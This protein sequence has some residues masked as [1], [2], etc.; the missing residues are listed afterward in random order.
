MSVSSQKDTNSELPAASEKRWNGLTMHLTILRLCLALVLLTA[1]GIGIPTYVNTRIVASR[2][3][4]YLINTVAQETVD[5]CRDYLGRANPVLEFNRDVLIEDSKYGVLALKPPEESIWRSRGRLLVRSLQANVQLN[6][7]Y[8]GDKW[9]DYIGAVRNGKESIQIDHR[10]IADKKS[11]RQV[12]R[13]DKL[14]IWIEISQ[15][16]FDYDPRSRPWYKSALQKKKMIWT[17]PYLF[18]SSRRPGITA[19]LPLLD[20]DKSVVGVCGIDYELRELNDFVRKQ[21]PG[22]DGKLIILAGSSGAE[23]IVAQPWED[24]AAVPGEKLSVSDSN[25]RLMPASRSSQPVVRSIGSWMQKHSGENRAS[26]NI[27]AI[28]FDAGKTKYLAASLPFILGDQSWSVTAAI[29]E[30]EVLGDVNRSGFYTILWVCGAI[31][32]ASLGAYFFSR[33]VSK[34]LRAIAHEMNLAGSLEISNR[35]LP[36]SSVREVQMMG[37]SL[38]TMKSGLRAFE[39]YVSTDLVRAI[40]INKTAVGLGGDTQPITVFF[41]DVVGFT[42]YSEHM[43]PAD[44]VSALAEYLEIMEEIVWERKGFVDK[45][46]GDAVMAL[47]D[48]PI[49]PD[50]Q[51]AKLA[52]HAALDCVNRL[53]ELRATRV[54]EGQPYFEINIGIHTGEALVGNIGSVRRWNYTAMGDT[55]NLASRIEPLNRIYGTRIL[56]SESTYEEVKSDFET[57]LIDRVIVKGRSEPILIFELM[58]KAGELE[59]A[60]KPFV[61]TYS[62]GWRHYQARE[63]QKAFE[64]FGLAADLSSHSDRASLLLLERCGRYIHTPPSQEWDGAYVLTAK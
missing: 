20:S 47:W 54:D 43:K 46:I 6:Q 58:A 53:S 29:P 32:F 57:R 21:H 33:Q 11:H 14:G 31:I 51:A 34:P 39:K 50:K 27:S 2:L 1:V 8:Y 36:D 45:Y 42:S 49:R 40:L 10:W 59:D 37:Q 52:C 7:V 28:E 9:G 30:D 13:V 60:R 19:A 3:A 16:Q 5:K 4:N 12:Y 55:V 62:Q 18:A 56:I 61:N 23:S 64:K 38:E 15:P 24:M 63:W 17:I 48:T 41:A 22:K 26:R 35:T 25:L 44:V